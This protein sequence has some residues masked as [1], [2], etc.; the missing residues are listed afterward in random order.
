MA[1]MPTTKGLSMQSM[2]KW[3]CW[4]AIGVAGVLALLFILD[5]AVGFPFGGGFSG[6]SAYAGD[7]TV[8]DIFGVITAG[9]ILYLGYNVYRDIR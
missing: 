2:P 7:V 3:L 1:R 8:I 5:L 9:I 6:S 4:G